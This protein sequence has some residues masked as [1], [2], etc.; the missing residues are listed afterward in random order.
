MNSRLYDGLGLIGGGSCWI[1]GCS[2]DRPVSLAGE[3]ALVGVDVDQ[4]LEL[5]SKA[6]LD[7]LPGRDRKGQPVTFVRCYGIDDTSNGGC[8]LCGRTL[9]RA[10]AV[11]HRATK[12]RS[13]VVWCAGG[14]A[15]LPWHLAT[16][17][18]SDDRTQVHGW[19]EVLRFVRDRPVSTPA[20]YS[21]HGHQSL[22][23]AQRDGR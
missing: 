13:P 9:S 20:L 10:L 22:H 12:A 14:E 1:E 23:G 3:K 15:N 4:P 17:S 18:P 6:C 11:S 8:R 2:I 19:T 16:N 5:P 7:L 21:F